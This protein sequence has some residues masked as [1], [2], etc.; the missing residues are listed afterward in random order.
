VSYVWSPSVT[1][2]VVESL[3]ITKVELFPDKT[4]VNVGESVKFRVRAYF[5][6]T[7]TD[8]DVGQ[9]ITTVIAVNTQGNI[10]SM[11]SEYLKS[12]ISYYE[13]T[14]TYKFTSPGTYT[15]WG[16]AKL[17][18]AA[19][20]KLGYGGVFSEPVVITVLP[21]YGVKGYPSPGILG[22]IALFGLGFVAGAYVYKLYVEG[23]LKIP[24]IAVVR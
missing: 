20:T 4:T 16:G 13:Y 9:Y 18:V 11:W 17:G 5:N 2:T 14:H 3:S 15:V 6:R 22:D 23:K 21:E 7:T 8:Y 24:K 10:V 1:I 12:G 19:Y